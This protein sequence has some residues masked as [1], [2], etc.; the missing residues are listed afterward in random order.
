MK[1]TGTSKGASMFDLTSLD[2]R[3]AE[4]ERRVSRIDKDEWKQSA[5]VATVSTRGTGPFDR[6]LSASVNF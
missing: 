5:D 1:Q 4:H 6:I 3:S 2:Q